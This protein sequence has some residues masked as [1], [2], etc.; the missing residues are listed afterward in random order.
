MKWLTLSVFFCLVTIEVFPQINHSVS[1]EKFHP[2]FISYIGKDQQE[3]TKVSSDGYFSVREKGY[4]ELPIKIIRLLIPNNTSVENIE[5][6]NYEKTTQTIIK[7]IYPVQ[8][9]DT[10]GFTKPNEEIYYSKTPY[11]QIPIQVLHHDIFDGHNQLVSL[12]VYPIQY[13]PTENKIDI[14]SQ[15]DFN[16][17]LKEN[18][19]E[20]IFPQKRSSYNQQLYDDILTSMIDN[21]E[22]ISRYKVSA[23]KKSDRVTVPPPVDFYDYVII[24]TSALESSFDNFIAWKRRKGIDIG[25]VTTGSISYYYTGDYVSGIFDEAGKIRQYL[26]DAYEL[27][28]TWVLLGGDPSIVP[29]RESYGHNILN[30]PGLIGYSDL[31]YGDRNGNWNVDDDS[32]YGEPE[33]DAVDYAPELFVGRLLC[34]SGQEIQNWTGKVLKYEQYPGNGSYSYLNRNMMIQSDEPQHA[35]AIGYV[36]QKQPLNFSTQSYNELPSYDSQLPTAPYS[37]TIINDFNSTKYGMWFWFAHGSQTYTKTMSSGLNGAT[38]SSLNTNNLLS[39]SNVN[40]PS[41]LYS[42]ACENA[43][44]NSNPNLARVYT[45]TS[46]NGGPA[47]LGNSAFGGTNQYELTREFIYMFV[48]DPEILK[49]SVLHLGMAESI[50]KYEYN[51]HI[52]SLFHNLIGCPEMPVWNKT[53]EEFNQVNII[54]G[55]S[56]ITVNTGISGC[57]ICVSST[58]SGGSFYQVV[59]NK[60][61]YTFNTTVRP[62]YVT[63]TKKH[64]LPYSVITGGSLSSVINLTGKI[65]ISDG[66]YGKKGAKIIIEPNTSLVFDNEKTFT[67]PKKIFLENS[68]VNN[69]YEIDKLD[70]FSQD[71]ENNNLPLTKNEFKGN[72]PNPFNPSTNLIYSLSE[73]SIV[74]ITIYNLLGEIIKEFN[75]GRQSS[76]A[77]QVQWNG[78][79]LNGVKASSGVYFIR[80]KAIPYKTPN[81]AFIQTSKLIMMR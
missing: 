14:I 36:T 9:F 17:I 13:F 34:S 21:P 66:L 42:I 32:R 60:S 20:Y 79:N 28:T 1:F 71:T 8:S 49:T 48:D 19:K 80:F 15:I 29:S 76:G 63:V 81:N 12:V 22:D 38:M 65:K 75:I 41:I 69:I 51:F 56:S 64:Y 62:L 55:G 31:Y 26:R 50:S 3:Y 30:D 18:K 11:P 6:L 4:P 27:G 53:P 68:Q 54:D 39:L 46:T 47:F 77:H 44:Y 5:I 70:K 43:R 10:Q 33:D 23:P 2:N 73:E 74:N 7:P 37:S 52:Y 25:I 16:L 59:H 61:S 58:G 67:S 45:T 72:F 24:T 57:T 78:D 40:Y 35:N